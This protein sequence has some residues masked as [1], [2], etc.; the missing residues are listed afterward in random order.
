[1]AAGTHPIAFRTRQLRP[2]APMVLGGNPPGRVGRRRV[3]S[4]RPKTPAQ[5]GGRLRVRC[6]S[7]HTEVNHSVT[8]R[9]PRRSDD[10]PKRASSAR[11]GARRSTRGDSP[12]RAT[13]GGRKATR[14]NGVAKRAAGR[15][16]SPSREVRS[17][18]TPRRAPRAAG[19]PKRAAR[20]D[21]AGRRELRRDGPQKR[22]GRGP[23]KRGAGAGNDRK[24]KR[25]SR[26]SDDRNPTHSSVD[27]PTPKFRAK[28]EEEAAPP[29]SARSSLRKVRRPKPDTT[30]TPTRRRPP[31]AAPPTR[32][33][34]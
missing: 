24:G 7:P 11:G 6:I 2:P 17:D 18:G 16:G 4:L 21:G 23:V 34:K 25:T 28:H 26:N 27:Y 3:F 20:T 30:P 15:D 13:G 1:M 12:P 19:G 8:E 10:G 33:A 31:R 9:K 32:R 22:T 14:G 29:S 5:C